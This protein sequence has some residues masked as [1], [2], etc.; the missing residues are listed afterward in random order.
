M[1][2]GPCTLLDHALSNLSAQPFRAVLDPDITHHFPVLLIFDADVPKKCSSRFT[3]VF[4]SVKFR[5][6]IRATD[7][8][9]INSLENAEVALQHF[10]SAFLKAVSSSTTTVKCKK[11][12]HLPEQSL[13]Y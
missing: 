6:A 4:D 10:S 12:V 8:C 1:R 9:T 5:Q 3:S 13:G 11:K 2:N 7:W